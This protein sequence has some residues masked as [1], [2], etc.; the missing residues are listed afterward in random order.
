MPENTDMTPSPKAE[1][2]LLKR[3]ERNQ[4]IRRLEAR[5]AQTEDG[6]KSDQEQVGGNILDTFHRKMGQGKE[7]LSQ[8]MLRELAWQKSR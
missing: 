5:L 2:M 6:T 7:S 1:T 3:F 8:E 4:G